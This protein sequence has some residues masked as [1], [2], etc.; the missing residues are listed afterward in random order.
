MQQLDLFLTAVADRL[1][2]RHALNDRV[3]AVVTGVTDA[4]QELRVFYDFG[5]RRWRYY[6][7]PQVPPEITSWWL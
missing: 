7:F 2:A 4:G 3:S 6:G 1:P 5:E